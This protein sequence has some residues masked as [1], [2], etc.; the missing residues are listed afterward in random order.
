MLPSETIKMYG[1]IQGE[2]GSTEKGFCI[3]GAMD[4]A[5]NNNLSYTDMRDAVVAVH[6]DF[7]SW[8]NKPGRT[9]QEVIDLLV[10]VGL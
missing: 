2:V 8:N 5:S 9:K 4:Y 6:K 1:W 7:V 10:S 3:V